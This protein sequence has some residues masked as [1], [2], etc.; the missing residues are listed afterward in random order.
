MSSFNSAYDRPNNVEEVTQQN[1]ETILDF[2]LEQSARGSKTL[3]DNVAA[4]Q[5]LCCPSDI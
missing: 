3:S 4:R 5:T 1:V 2:G